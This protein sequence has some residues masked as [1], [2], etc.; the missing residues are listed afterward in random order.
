MQFLSITTITFFLEVLL[1]SVSCWY[2]W[3]FSHIPHSLNV[4]WNCVW[5]I[6]YSRKS[7]CIDMSVS[8]IQDRRNWSPNK[9]KSLTFLLL[10][11]LHV[12]LL[13]VVIFDEG[14]NK[15][16]ERSGFYK[17]KDSLPCR[18]E[19]IFMSHELLVVTNHELHLYSLVSQMRI[20][21]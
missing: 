5:L 8:W 20:C 11:Q 2:D 3:D 4:G 18:F 12:L 9:E 6:C 10:L 7:V 17:F 21:V 13:V 15:A 1:G 19:E 16:V 14:Y